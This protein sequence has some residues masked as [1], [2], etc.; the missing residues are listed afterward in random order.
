MK[1]LTDATHIELISFLNGLSS[2]MGS[3]TMTLDETGYPIAVQTFYSL[4]RNS[5]KETTRPIIGNQNTCNK[6]IVAT[7]DSLIEEIAYHAEDYPGEEPPEDP[8][9]FPFSLWWDDL[10]QVLENNLDESTYRLTKWLLEELTNAAWVD[11]AIDNN[12]GNSKELFG[13]L[14]DGQR[15][16]LYYVIAST[17]SLLYKFLDSMDYDD[18]FNLVDTSS[19]CPKCTERRAEYLTLGDDDNTITCCTC[20]TV[21]QLN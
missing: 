3:T 12:Y 9:T 5:I 21:Y 11:E 7:I 4:L 19:A 8:I 15:A 17:A 14:Q 2:F 10:D 20:G 6:A 1:T 18:T 16:F 13:L